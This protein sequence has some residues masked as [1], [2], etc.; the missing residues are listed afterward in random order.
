MIIVYSLLVLNILIS[1]LGF[2]YAL[3]QIRDHTLPDRET[4]EDWMVDIEPKTQF[5][6][7]TTTKEKFDNS[8]VIDDLLNHE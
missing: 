4:E 7:S 8:E 2:I 6:E 3:K 5:L 1:I